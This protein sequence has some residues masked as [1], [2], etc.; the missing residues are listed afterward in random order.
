VMMR[1]CAISR[2]HETENR[3][4]GKHAVFALGEEW[5]GVSLIGTSDHEAATAAL[6]DLDQA[7]FTR[8]DERLPESRRSCAIRSQHPIERAIDRDCD[9]SDRARPTFCIC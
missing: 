3:C 9:I 2:R 1:K 5:R 8:C 4:A 6:E 7:P